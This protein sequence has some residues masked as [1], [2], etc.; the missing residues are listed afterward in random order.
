MSEEAQAR[1][2]GCASRVHERQARF[3]E[4][5]GG[6]RWEARANYTISRND[7]S[8]TYMYPVREKPAFCTISLPITAGMRWTCRVR[9]ASGGT[10]AVQQLQ[11]NTG[12]KELKEVIFATQKWEEAWGARMHARESNARMA[13]A[14]KGRSYTS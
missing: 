3:G 6:E 9:H 1:A 8:P 11:A 7:R 4:E 2:D 14:W 13:I 10:H 5:V 12:T